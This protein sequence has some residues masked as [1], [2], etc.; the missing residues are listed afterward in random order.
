VGN[1]PEATKDRL[2]SYADLLAWSRE[3]GL[4]DPKETRTLARRASDNPAEAQSAFKGAIEVRETL[5]RIY[6]ALARGSQPGRAD[7]AGLNDDLSHALPFARLAAGGEG[8]RWTWSGESLDRPLWPVIR[9]AAD[10]LTSDELGFVRECGSASCSWLFIDRSRTRRRRWCDMKTCGN[11]QKARRY[12]QRHKAG[13]T[14]T[15]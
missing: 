2:K 12:Y 10:L 5:Y 4:L 11:R 7:L 14:A 6:S 15:Y 13:G 8:Y 9:S 1:R 3:A